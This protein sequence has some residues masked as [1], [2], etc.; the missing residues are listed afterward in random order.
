MTIKEF[1]RLRGVKRCTAAEYAAAR[2]LWEEIFTPGLKY[3]RLLSARA[4]W[5]KACEEFS[6]AQAGL[7]TKQR[8]AIARKDNKGLT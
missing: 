7:T 6:V 4:A 1:R 5:N 3:Q 2:E 8:R